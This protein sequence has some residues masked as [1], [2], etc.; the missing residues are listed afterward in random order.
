MTREEEKRILD[1][2]LPRLSPERGAKLLANLAIMNA[3]I[4]CSDDRIAKLRAELAAMKAAE[5]EQ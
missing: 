4:A 5:K 1:W 3:R 2:L